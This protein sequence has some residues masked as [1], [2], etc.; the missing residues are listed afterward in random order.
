VIPISAF[1]F[2]KTDAWGPQGGRGCLHFICV[3]FA[4]HRIITNE[5]NA[6]LTG[7]SGMKASKANRKMRQ[8]SPIS[9]ALLCFV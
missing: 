2:L 5:H 1:S 8:V 4:L 6:K 9:F 3:V 7:F